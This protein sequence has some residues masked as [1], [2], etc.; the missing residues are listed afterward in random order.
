MAELI[1]NGYDGGISIEPHM[2]RVF[3][4]ASAGKKSENESENIYTEYGQRIMAMLER[5]GGK[6]E[7][8]KRI[9]NR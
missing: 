5:L 8:G 6:L 7:Q 3:H 9:L 4:D 1:N 2:A